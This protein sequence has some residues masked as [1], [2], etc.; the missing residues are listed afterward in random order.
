MSTPSESDLSD[1]RRTDNPDPLTVPARGIATVNGRPYF[2]QAGQPHDTCL[3]CGRATPLGVSLC[4][5]DNPAHI[6]APSTTQVHGT[7]VAGL[8]VAFVLVALLGRLLIVEKG[9]FDAALSGRIA[10]T[11]GAVDV[12]LQVTNRGKNTTPA[13]CRV[14][15][16]GPVSE[17][18]DLVFLTAP[19]PPGVATAFEKTLPAPLPGDP[20]WAIDGLVATCL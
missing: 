14:G 15:R 9:P 7:I 4:D 5:A 1:P 17:K 11:D 16:G 12:V 13:T 2:P 6:G 8:I 19:L 20:A 18:Q 3:R 10:R